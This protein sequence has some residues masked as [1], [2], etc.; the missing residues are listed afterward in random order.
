M[1]DLLIGILIISLAVWWA[2]KNPHTAQKVV[3]EFEGVAAKVVNT[4]S[5]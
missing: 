3:N 1:R 2:V 5:D 4:V